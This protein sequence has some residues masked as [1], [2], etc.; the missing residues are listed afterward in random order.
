[1][2]VPPGAIKGQ[3]AFSRLHPKKDAD[4]LRGLRKVSA[5]PPRGLSASDKA[6]IKQAGMKPTAR[7]HEQRLPKPSRPG[8]YTS[9]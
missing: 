5:A 9:G 7:G 1:M 4:F 3:G 8:R 2:S 6:T